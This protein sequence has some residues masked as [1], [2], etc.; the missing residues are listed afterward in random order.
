MKKKGCFTAASVIGGT[1]AIL[2]GFVVWFFSHA[3][4]DQSKGPTSRDKALAHC[5]FRLPQS[6][7]NIQYASY[8]SGMQEGHFYVRFEAP[9]TDCFD[10]AKA[11]FAAHAK[12]FPNYVIPEF[13]PVSHP[14]RT[15]NTD[16]RIDWFDNDQISKGV[17][18]GTGWAWEPKVWID[19]EG[20]IFYFE[21]N[22]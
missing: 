3:E 7:S 6:A 11:I 20:G 4:I 16:L 15:R 1:A 19:E 12:N 18:A 13:T 22:D 10:T 5:S 8:A 17:V 21:V 14:P 2:F 9:V